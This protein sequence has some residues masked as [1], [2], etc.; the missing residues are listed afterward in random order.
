MPRASLLKL[1]DR[2]ELH[3]E[4]RRNADFIKV[5]LLSYIDYSHE[6]TSV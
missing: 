3:N 1:S 5:I 2:C 6:D 4:Y